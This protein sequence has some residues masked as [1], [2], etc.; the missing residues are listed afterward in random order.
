[1]NDMATPLRLASLAHGG[2]CGCK[3]APGVLT[4]ILKSIPLRALPPELLGGTE[5]NED[6]AV[7]AGISTGASGRNWAGYGKEIALAAGI[8]EWQQKLLTDPQTSGGL[9]VACAPDC[10]EEVLW[11][12][13]KEGFGEARRI[14]RFSGGLPGL[15]VV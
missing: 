5:N 13:A 12:F 10:E 3:I 1:M 6:A 8:A 2:G 14:G 7:K 4:E 9:L 11:L 15:R